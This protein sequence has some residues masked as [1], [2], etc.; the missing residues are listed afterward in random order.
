[1]LI[2]WFTVIAQIFN[3]LLLLW[4]LRRF[5]YGPIVAAMEAREQRVAA[6]LEQARTKEEDAEQKVA[7]YR[8]KQWELEQQ[9]VGL[10][11]QA[12]EQAHQRR[13]ELLAEARDE[14]ARL[15]SNWRAALQ[16][17]KTAFLRDLRQ[18]C[19]EQVLAIARRVMHDLA[20]A[21]LEQQIVAVFLRRLSGLEPATRDRINQAL[22]ES[23]QQARLCSAFELSH[24]QRR[25]LKNTVREQFGEDVDLNFVRDQQLIGGLALIIGSH[26]IAWNLQSYLEALEDDIARMFAEETEAEQQPAGDADTEAEQQLAEE[27]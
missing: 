16:Q 7:E 19:G 20:D 12:E 24:E 11:H 23:Q 10:L 14:A 25:Q 13:Q 27:R 21:E 17:S 6:H 9:R 15:S 1:M 5:L 3:F 4:L 8:Q 22:E 2:D 26:E 18:R